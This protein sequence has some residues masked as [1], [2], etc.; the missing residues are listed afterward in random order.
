MDSLAHD[1]Y[2]ELLLDPNAFH[3]GGP[4]NDFG[5]LGVRFC[6]I[7]VHFGDLGVHLGDLGVR[8]GDLGAAIVILGCPGYSSWS[9]LGCAWL[10]F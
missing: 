4:G 7:G 9:I 6:D 8:F 3:V 2:M 1:R 5:D 10:H